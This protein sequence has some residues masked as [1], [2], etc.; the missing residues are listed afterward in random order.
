M[1]M[2]NA[3]TFSYTSKEPAHTRLLAIIDAFT[4]QPGDLVSL[5]DVPPYG[6]L[7][8]RLTNYWQ[9]R[10]RFIHAGIGVPRTNQI[11]ALLRYVK[12]PLLD[13]VRTSS[14]F[15]PAYYPLLSIA[16]QLYRSNP[17]LAEKLLDELAAANPL[18]Q[19]ARQLK[20][21][22]GGRKKGS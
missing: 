3:P 22:L 10:N 6:Q 21:Y 16:N 13:I 19:D 12:D 14:E 18:R 17:L 2:F 7:S 4:P 20:R 9:A 11:E 15:D 8:I 5:Y 1:V